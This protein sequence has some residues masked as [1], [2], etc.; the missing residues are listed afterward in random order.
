MPRGFV[1]NNGKI[2]IVVHV[3]ECV[4]DTTSNGDTGGFGGITELI[5]RGMVPVESMDRN[6][7]GR[8]ICGNKHNRWGSPDY[9]KTEFSMDRSGKKVRYSEGRKIKDLSK[10]LGPEVPSCRKG[11]DSSLQLLR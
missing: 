8:T 6:Y 9:K 10:K 3:Y 7:Q 5:A 1:V 4:P 11:V 2:T